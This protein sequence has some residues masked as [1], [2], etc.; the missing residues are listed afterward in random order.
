MSDR[1]KQGNLYRRANTITAR[2]IKKKRREDKK[3]KSTA[4]TSF[5]RRMRNNERAEAR[6]AE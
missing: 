3:Y 4:S 1:N 2:K 6:T 5:E